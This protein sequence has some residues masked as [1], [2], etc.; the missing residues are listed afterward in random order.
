ME[1]SKEVPQKIKNRTTYGPAIPPLGIYPKEMKSLSQRHRSMEQDRKPRD[2][3]T[4][5]WST[6]L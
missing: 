5:L 1:N 3:P 2:K 4:H 6:N